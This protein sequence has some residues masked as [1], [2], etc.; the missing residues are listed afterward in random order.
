MFQFGRMHNTL[1]VRLPE[2]LA[3]WLSTTA[4]KSGVSQGR[5]VREQL[6][7]ARREEE[8]PFMRLVGAGVGPPD[9][10]QRKGFSRS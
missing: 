3:D 10:S 5:I 9:L 1:T 7:K 8:P 6:E 2:D 4:R